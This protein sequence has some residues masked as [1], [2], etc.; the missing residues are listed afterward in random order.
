MDTRVVRCLCV[1]LILFLV[2]ILA[3]FPVDH[4]RLVN[5]WRQRTHASFDVHPTLHDLLSAP[6]PAEAASSSTRYP[7]VAH[8]GAS[9]KK[10]PLKIAIIESMGWHDEV[11]AALVHAFGSQPDV[12]L[13]LFF[14]NPRWGMPDLLKTFQLN[15]SLPDYVYHNINALDVAEPDIIVSTTCEYDVQ[16]LNGRLDALF[17]RRKT[18]LFCTARYANEWNDRHEW[19]EPSLTK[20]IEAG[21]MTILTL[22]PHVQKGFHKPGWGL[23][24]WD[25]LNKSSKT[26]HLRL[27]NEESSPTSSAISWPPIEVFVPIF[28]IL[29]SGKENAGSEDGQKTEEN[30][31]LAIQGGVNAARDYDRIFGY[32]EDLVHSNLTAHERN[33]VSLHI[34]GSGSKEDTKP[35]VPASLSDHVFFDEG[36]D[37]IDYYADLSKKSALIPAFAEEE[38][39]TVRSSSSVP[40]SVIA[41]IPLVATR[42]ILDS[43]SYLT[44]EDVYLQEAHESELDVIERVVKASHEERR[45]KITSVGA[46]RDRMIEDNLHIVGGWIEQAR[47]KIER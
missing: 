38:F 36:L 12:Q 44:V 34:I 46:M 21:L 40:A 7:L 18:Y 15:A 10:Q 4:K 47:G 28:P 43:Y 3:L 22:S 37:Y 23:S 17:E 5:T 39:L 42:E 35:I 16:N 14:K 41:G 26:P 33:N 20:W 1:C 24:E 25:G 11:Y 31:A 13:S 45:Q 30:V 8:Q 29:E 9:S 6:Y 32:L 27:E 19:L 2:A